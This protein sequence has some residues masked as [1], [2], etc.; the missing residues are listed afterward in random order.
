MACPVA[1]LCQAHI[2][3]VAPLPKRNNLAIASRPGQVA[4]ERVVAFMRVDSIVGKLAS[5]AGNA[6]RFSSKVGDGECELSEIDR[7]ASICCS[8]STAQYLR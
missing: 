8:T 2:R 5:D 3:I 7:V 4:N 6:P 1:D